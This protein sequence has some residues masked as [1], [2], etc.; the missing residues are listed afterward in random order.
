[1]STALG[2]LILAFYL[3]E[4]ALGGPYRPEVVTR[5][6]A[7]RRDLVLDHGEGW[8]LL[9]GPFLHGGVVH[10]LLNGLAFVQLAPLVELIYGRWRL[11]AVYLASALG[12]ALASVLFLPLASVGASG[13]ILGLAG[14]LLGTSWFG[15]DPWRADLR[16]LF[17][18]WLV[19][20]V[21]LT[22]AVGVGLQLLWAP[23]VD[24]P[25]H[26]G[27]LLTGLL[28]SLLLRRPE[29]R[30][31]VAVELAAG[32][33]GGLLLVAIVGMARDGGRAAESAQDDQQAMLL[34][35]LHRDARG[36]LAR[37]LLPEMTQVLLAT[38]LDAEGEWATGAWLAQAPG[39]PHALNA[40]AWFL[41]TRPEEERRDPVAA[42]PLARAAVSTLEA[43][44][45]PP[46]ELAA[47]LDTEAVVLRGLG[48]PDE[49]VA[50]ERRV[51]ELCQ[52]V[53]EASEGSLLPG[54]AVEGGASLSL[55][56]DAFRRQGERRG[57]WE[58][59]LR[60]LAL[61]PQ[62]PAPSRAR[63]EAL[64]AFPD[65][66]SAGLALA[67]ARRAEGL[68]LPAGGRPTQLQRREAA[69]AR[70]LEARALVRLG[71]GAEAA[72]VEAGTI[73]LLGDVMGPGEAAARARRARI[74]PQLA[75][76]T[77]DTGR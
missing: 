4:L 65:A 26:L 22:F 70:D 18:P 37:R 60:W 44:Q 11:L 1:M 7:V 40:R 66:G 2:A 15:A 32:L 63:A 48:R 10:L 42:L 35:E 31:G 53:A 41:V 19:G 21:L 73:A 74:G 13:A 76:V 57:A 50:L 68:A 27:G 51:V 29:R 39:D 56:H 6:G 17:G 36:S 59:L 62:D 24:N 72:A 69:R 38:G 23:I 16:R 75:P 64:L 34:A 30:E 9:C 54:A 8:R 33:L 49:A 28:A 52:P 46:L 61:A 77:P 3:L 71:R 14:L 20:S 12:G 67:E 45:A 5:L 25:G 58:A 47:A 43:Q 55:L